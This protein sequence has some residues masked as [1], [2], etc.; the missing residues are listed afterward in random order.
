MATPTDDRE[1]AV[2]R[3]ARKALGLCGDTRCPCGAD[4]DFEVHGLD[5]FTELR[6]VADAI[7]QGMALAEQDQERSRSDRDFIEQKFR[8][9]MRAAEAKEPDGCPYGEHSLAA[10]WWTR[11]FASVSS[12]LED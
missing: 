11:G 12:P 6:A 2:M 7:R 10:H 5:A 3:L 1:A 9:G 8:E 4:H